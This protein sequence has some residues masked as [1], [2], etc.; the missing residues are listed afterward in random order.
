MKNSKWIRLT[1]TLALVL[2]SATV[3]A[4]GK[5]APGAGMR[6]S[7]HDW[8][9][10]GA[11]V[12]I[13]GLQVGLCSICHTPHSAI[14]TQLLWN[15]KLS[16]ATYTWG[17]ATETTGGTPLPSSANMGPSTKCLSCHDGTV[18]V[19]DTAAYNGSVGGVDATHTFGTVVTRIAQNGVYGIG[20]GT[21][22]MK[23]NH[24]IGIPYPLNGATGIYNG[25]TVGSQV[26][27]TS[28]VAMPA[29]PIKLYNDNGSGK[30]SD[31]AVA[32]KAGIECT[33]C[34]DPHNKATTDEFFLRGKNHGSSLADGYICLQCH[35]K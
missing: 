1:S 29:A 21:D 15:Q 14:S 16:T 3:L 35:I 34:H 11:L 31:G 18:A 5:P 7:A 2:V 30:I 28:F 19:G 10:T 4:A 27:H 26:D 25:I 32:G 33:S 20:G 12:P 22:S 24:P 13:S 8:S 23:G 17:D 9:G 6:G